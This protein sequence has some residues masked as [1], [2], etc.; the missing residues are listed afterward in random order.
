MDIVVTRTI[1]NTCKTPETKSVLTRS[2]RRFGR[3][4][5]ERRNALG[6]VVMR[7]DCGETISL[8]TRQVVDGKHYQCE[9]CDR[10][11]RKTP[12]RRFLGDEIYLNVVGR[13]RNAKRR[14]E[15]PEDAGWSNYGGI[16]ITFDFHDVEHY[17]LMVGMLAQIYG[18]DNE[19]DRRDNSRGYSPENVR[20][21]S[22][23]DNIRN[24]RNTIMIEGIPLAKIAEDNGLDPTK[25]LSRYI[26]MRTRLM[27]MMCVGPVSMED[28][29]EVVIEFRDKPQNE[30]LRKKSPYEKLK[31]NGV[32]LMEFIADM[33]FPNNRALYS[34]AKDYLRPRRKR[35]EAMNAEELRDHLVMYAIRRNIKSTPR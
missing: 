10:W 24:R 4:S 34:A 5:V 15:N 25:H 16:G 22:R 27:D 9:S 2:G 1:Q 29:V 19:V 20:L 32:P 7:C 30:N 14:C 17:A 13:G 28:V 3:L 11:D 23:K 6:H 33:G 12:V 26:S 35:G 31:I 8:T 18:L 21:I